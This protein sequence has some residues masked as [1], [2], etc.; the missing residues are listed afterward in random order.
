MANASSPL[1]RRYSPHQASRP[2]PSSRARTISTTSRRRPVSSGGKT[3]LPFNALMATVNPGD[4]VIA[5]PRLAGVLNPRYQV[6]SGGKP[7]V[8]VKCTFEN[9]FPPRRP[10]LLEKAI[11]PTTNG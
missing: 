10:E 9:G 5:C 1:C 6:A 3:I 2:P 4:E 11:T 7:L 8:I